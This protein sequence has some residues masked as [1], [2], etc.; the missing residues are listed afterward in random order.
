MDITFTITTEQQRAV[1]HILALDSLRGANVG[2]TVEQYIESEFNGLLGK[3]SA[4]AEVARVDFVKETIPSLDA[5]QVA[6]LAEYV[7]SLR[8]P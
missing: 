2:M 5:T 3:L 4:K 1:A 8:N 7:W 6:A